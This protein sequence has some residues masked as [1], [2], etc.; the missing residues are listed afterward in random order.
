[1]RVAKVRAVICDVYHTLL[2]VGAGPADAEERWVELWRGYGM[3]PEGTLAWFD[4]ACARETGA[5]NEARRAGGE[6]WPEVEWESVVVAVAPRL[7]ELAA[8][9][10][11]EFLFGHARLE[12]TVELMPGAGEVLGRLREAGVVLGIASNG[13]GYTRR[14]LAWVGL[15]MEWLEEACCFWS[16][17]HGYSKPSAAVFGRLS[18]ALGRVG[19]APGEVVMVGDREDN[20][21]V[22]ARAAG[23]RAW[24]FRDEPGGDW[25]AVGEWLLP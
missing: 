21:V 6:R 22:P 14:E 15:R 23:W 2:R 3:E 5:R 4:G 16:G 12:R 9:E 18:E 1:V 10:L 24:H 17:D 8:G 19:I 20:D 13:Q 7:G 11:D 25:E